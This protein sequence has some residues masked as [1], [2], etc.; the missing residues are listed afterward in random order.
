MH[1]TPCAL[2]YLKWEQ[3]DLIVW[4]MIVTSVSRYVEKKKEQKRNRV[5]Y[6]EVCILHKLG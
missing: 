3:D 4:V 1:C 5:E 6:E 2:A